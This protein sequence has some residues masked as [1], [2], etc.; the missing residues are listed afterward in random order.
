MKL[1]EAL[2]L[3]ADVKRRM[4]ELKQR[5]AV[6]VRVQ[7]GDSPSEDPA[8]LRAEY[9]RLADQMLTLIRSINV[10]NMTVR[11]DDGQSIADALALRD[12]LR[13]RQTLLRNTLGSA[14]PTERWGR[15]EIR[16][17]VTIDIP[18]WRSDADELARELRELDTRIQAVNWTVD[19]IE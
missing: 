2:I 12:I 9:E 3:R 16:Y 11:L 4:D 10:S 19:L 18:T 17:V 13:L 5:L 7:E 6:T 14:M 15:N 8:K 1:A